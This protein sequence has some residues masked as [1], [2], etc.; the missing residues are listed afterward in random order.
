[1]F[2]QLSGNG[3]AVAIIFLIELVRAFPVLIG[4]DNLSDFFLAEM[5]LELPRLPHDRFA[6]NRFLPME[7]SL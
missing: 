1:M 6:I 4:A 5:L 3:V 2:F 7:R